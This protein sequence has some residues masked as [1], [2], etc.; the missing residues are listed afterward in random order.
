MT[1]SGVADLAVR[2]STTPPVACTWPNAPNSTLVNERFIARHMM[3]ERIRPDDPSSAPA[4]M[5]SLFSSTNPIA[6]AD[7]PAYE[8]NSEITV[9]MS[10]PP[11][12]ST[13]S[14]PNN[15]DSTM[16]IG[17]SHEVSGR[18]TSTIAITIATPSRPRLMTFWL[19]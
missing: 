14:T 12:G 19:R 7:S 5:S 6:T 4:V 13:S 17:N 8:F 3:I 16:T 2:C 9:G 15:S 1:S 11:I 10:A 18:N